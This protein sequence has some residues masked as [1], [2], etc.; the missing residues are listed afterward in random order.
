MDEFIISVIGDPASQGSH[1]II[2]GRIVQVNSAKLN[3][4]RKAIV[5]TAQAKLPEDWQPLDGPVELAVNFY[6]PKPKTVKRQQPTTAPDLDKL[7]RG[8]GDSLTMAGVITDD[9]RIVKIT[10]RKAY[11]SHMESGATISVRPI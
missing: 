6:M 10:A 5:E 4:W 2:N 11:A 8:V 9:S 7:I 3:R 1:S